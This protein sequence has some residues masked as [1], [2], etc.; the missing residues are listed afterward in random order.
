MTLVCVMLCT[1]ARY[2]YFF[3]LYGMA[4]IEEVEELFISSTA[5]S[6]ERPRQPHIRASACIAHIVAIAIF[7]FEEKN[8]SSLPLKP[9]R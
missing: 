5:I 9:Y 2:M 6:L 1:V 7:D 3:V 8:L 4:R